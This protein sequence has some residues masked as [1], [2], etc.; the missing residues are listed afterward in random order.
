MGRL[1]I[2]FGALAALS[3]CVAPASGRGGYYPVYLYEPVQAQQPYQYAAP[4]TT[5]C[6]T[7]GQNQIPVCTS[8]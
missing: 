1:V 8:F 4:V 3:A 2:A 6:H 7:I 5:T